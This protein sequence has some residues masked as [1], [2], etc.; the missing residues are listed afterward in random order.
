MISGHLREFRS[1]SPSMHQAFED[2]RTDDKKRD[3]GDDHQQSPLG[4]IVHHEIVRAQTR[5][6]DRRKW[7]VIVIGPAEYLLGLAARPT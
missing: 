1:A 4:W 6:R 3:C 2:E 7:E 5:T